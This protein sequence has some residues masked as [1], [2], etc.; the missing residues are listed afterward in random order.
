MR[1][2]AGTAILIGAILILATFMFFQTSALSENLLESLHLIEQNVEQGNWEEAL[3]E[4]K[5]LDKVWEK[6]DN[7]WTP[8]MDHKETE[9]LDMSMTR[10]SKWVEIHNKENALVEIGV[11]RRMV[12]NFRGKEVPNL[13]NIF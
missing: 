6:A 10:V 5:T 12:E 7:W 8:F 13:K 1:L 4:V 2:L 3:Q 11:A 9:L